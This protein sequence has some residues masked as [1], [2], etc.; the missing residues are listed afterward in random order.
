[1]SNRIKFQAWDIYKKVMIEVKG[2]KLYPA[3][4]WGV[5]DGETETLPCNVILRRFTGL[6]DKNGFEIF[7]GDRVRFTTYDKSSE[8]RQY[9]GTVEYIHSAFQEDKEYYPL[10]A[11]TSEMME[12]VGN[13]FEG[14]KEDPISADYRS[15]DPDERW[16]GKNHGD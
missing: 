11:F 3:G 9:V 8:G 10:A 4:D 2:L 15:H 7:E 5:W 12:I 14:I 16:P 1:M 6:L 13:E